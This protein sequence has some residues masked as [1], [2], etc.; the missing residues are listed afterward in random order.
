MVELIKKVS[1]G[2]NLPNDWMNSSVEFFGVQTKSKI[3]IFEKASLY[4]LLQN[5]KKCLV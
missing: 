4:Y 2:Q 1:I 3:I 5:G